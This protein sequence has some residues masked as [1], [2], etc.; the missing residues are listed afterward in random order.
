LPNWTKQ[1]SKKK[2]ST[3]HKDMHNTTLADAVENN[4]SMKANLKHNSINKD[5]S[6]QTYPQQTII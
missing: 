4:K 3:Y 2:G 6:T 5:P 1:N